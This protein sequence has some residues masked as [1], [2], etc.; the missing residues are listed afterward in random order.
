MGSLD[1]NG[2]YIYDETDQ[3]SP[4]HTFENLGQASVSQAIDDIHQ[5]TLIMPVAN[6]TERTAYENEMRSAGRPPSQARPLWV[7]MASD[8]TV[9]RNLG[10]G[11]RKLI[12]DYFDRYNFTGTS[13]GVERAYTYVIKKG[14][15]VQLNINEKRTAA[16]WTGDRQIIGPESGAG[17]MPARFRPAV[18][19]ST[20]GFVHRRDDHHRPFLIMVG[21]D[22]VVHGYNMVLQSGNW[23]RASV[24][25]PVIE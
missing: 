9:Y 4:I 25:W 15:W 17:Q 21:P 20:V 8:G 14:G 11:W 7:E 13:G 5:H 24:V 12:D 1:N 19:T 18:G 22:G 6:V 23:Y 10:T 3:V 16:E 2:I